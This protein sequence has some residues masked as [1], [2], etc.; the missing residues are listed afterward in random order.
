MFAPDTNTVSYFLRGEGRVAEKLLAT[1]PTLIA[2]PA[3]VVHELRYGALRG[4]IGERRLQELDAF[5]GCLAVLPLDDA[6][7]TAAAELRVAFE[8]QGQK[9][10]PLDVLI[11]GT[12]LSAGATLVTHNK[13]EFGR[14]PGLKLEDWY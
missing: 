4:G 3:V 9:I 8:Q 2:I 13:K 12:A 7:A 6:A 5:L 14:V 10:G 11:A 1:D